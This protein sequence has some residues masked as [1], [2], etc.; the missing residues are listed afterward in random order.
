[1]NIPVTSTLGFLGLIFL[2]VGLFLFLTGLDIFKVTQVTVM[3]GKKTWGAGLLFALVGIALLLPEILKNTQPSSSEIGLTQTPV[4]TDSIS[5]TPLPE[6]VKATET[7]K[8][9]TIDIPDPLGADV[10]EF[11]ASINFDIEP[12]GSLP[13]I[14]GIWNSEWNRRNGNW[15][16]GTATILVSDDNWIYI[17]QEDKGG[18]QYVVK[19]KLV[20]NRLVGRYINVNVE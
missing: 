7:A 8:A 12:K 3:P 4:F 6:T 9:P 1:M 20:D 15:V 10:L 5:G 17:I 11:A 16:T 14:G 18:G 19:A 2:A 13:N